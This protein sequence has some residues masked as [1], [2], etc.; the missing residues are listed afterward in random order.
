M[1]TFDQVTE[2]PIIEAANHAADFTFGD[3]PEGGDIGSSDVACCARD[4]IRALGFDADEIPR[5]DF[6]RVRE[7]V[8]NA[9]RDIV[10]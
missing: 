7:A 3:L 9:L 4:A 2:A 1:K 5:A 8:R 6:Q 10:L